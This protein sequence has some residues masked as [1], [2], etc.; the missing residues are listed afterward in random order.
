M[1]LLEEQV[2][3]AVEIGLPAA[4][5]EYQRRWK[6]LQEMEGD[7]WP[8]SMPTV[9]REMLKCGNANWTPRTDTERNMIFWAKHA[10]SQATLVQRATCVKELER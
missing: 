3:R 7:G 1:T 4:I 8:P 2:K 6:E 10:W 5:R 9:F